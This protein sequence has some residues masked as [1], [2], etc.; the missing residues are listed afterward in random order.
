MENVEKK[1]CKKCNKGLGVG[2]KVSIVIATYILFAAI[3]GTIKLI[4]ELSSLI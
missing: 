1:S 3:Y 4:K 2:H